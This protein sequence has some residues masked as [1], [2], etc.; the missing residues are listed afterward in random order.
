M[1]SLSSLHSAKRHKAVPTAGSSSLARVPHCSCDQASPAAASSATDAHS[2]HDAGAQSQGARGAEFA[3][4][5]RRDAADAMSPA[6]AS[7]PRRDG[8]APSSA[9]LEAEKAERKRVQRLTEKLA[10][11]KS[12]AEGSADGPKYAGVPPNTFSPDPELLFVPVDYRAA[13]W[14]AFQK[15]HLAP[16]AARCRGCGHW[17]AHSGP[18]TPLKEH[19][20]LHCK[21]S[22]DKGAR[23]R[24]LEATEV[25]K[26]PVPVEQ[27]QNTLTNFVRGE[28]DDGPMTQ[29]RK[30]IVMNALI[31]HIIHANQSLSSVDSDSFRAYSA[32]L[33]TGF[34][35]IGRTKLTELVDLRYAKCAEA[36]SSQLE[37]ATAVALTTDAATSTSGP[38]APPKRPLLMPALSAQATRCSA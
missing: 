26:K 28:L 31:D 29:K 12:R 35:C 24:Y 32:A 11:C 25:H 22:L 27:K 16:A 6:E 3:E 17:I 37:Q 13:V 19:I 15:C 33:N 7:G 21:L 18:T 1:A 38:C 9:P 10:A 34:H 23:K 14:V 36:V 20:V 4:A 8:A 2:G 30:N 5:A